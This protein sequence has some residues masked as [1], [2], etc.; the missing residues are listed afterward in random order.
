M[1]K[2]NFEEYLAWT[3]PDDDKRSTSG[4][5][6]RKLGQKIKDCLLGKGSFDK[7]FRWMVKRR[8]LSLLNLPS[9]GMKDVL[10]VPAKDEKVQLS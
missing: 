9:V 8:E 1:S 5:I 4:V 2:D 6:H 3:F 10:V 7:N